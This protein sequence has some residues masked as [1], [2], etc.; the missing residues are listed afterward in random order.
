M[1]VKIAIIRE[2]ARGGR[3]GMWHDFMHAGVCHGTEVEISREEF[4][5]IQANWFPG[6]LGNWVHQVLKP[7]VVVV[8]AVLG[9]EMKDCGGCA[10]RQVRLN[11]M[12]SGV[13]KG[14]LTED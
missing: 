12:V 2:A 11:A 6:G 7:A 13:V 10:G 8:D 1:R 3:A 4:D 9:T 5:R 14:G